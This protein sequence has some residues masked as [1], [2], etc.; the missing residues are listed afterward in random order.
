MPL[1]IA[2]ANTVLPFQRC[3]LTAKKK[4]D[5][6]DHTCGLFRLKYSNG[7]YTLKQSLLITYFTHRQ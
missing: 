6:N 4:A 7:E 1:H 2:N 3:T 5:N